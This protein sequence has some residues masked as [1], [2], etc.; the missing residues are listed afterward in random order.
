MLIR[1]GVQN[2]R[3]F[4]KESL[5][6]MLPGRT[7]QHTDH[8]LRPSQTDFELL[9]M[10]LLYGA[11]A[12]G[13]SNLVRAMAFARNL[14][15]SGTRPK[16]LLDA[17]PFRLRKDPNIVPS[18]FEFEFI[19]ENTA[20]AYGFVL[21]QRQIHEEW[22]FLIQRDKDVEEA[23]FERSTGK[24]GMTCA[25]FNSKRLEETEEQFL[26]FVARGTRPNQ[27]LL[28]ELIDKNVG[29]LDSVDRWFRHTLTIIFPESHFAGIEVGIHTDQEFAQGL[30]HFLRELHTGIDEVRL[31]EIDIESLPVPGE[32][33]DDL[34]LEFDREQESNGELPTNAL[35]VL[36]GPHKQRYMFRRTTDNKTVG[37]SLATIRR[38]GDQEIAFEISEES[39]GTQR[40]LDLFPVL[41]GLEE[42]VFVVD[43]LERSLHPNLVRRFIQHFLRGSGNNQLIVTSHEST[44]LDLSLLRR[45]EIWFVEKSSHGAST[46]YSLEEFKIRHDLDIRKGY[47]QGRFGAIPIFGSALQPE[48]LEA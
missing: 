35:V 48:P 29:A 39:D 27:L 30:A 12:S 46:L 40:L 28:T 34:T 5:L 26:Q 13:K 32:F 21:D 1:F 2:F 31:Q 20:Y 38:L 14:I 15:V 11:N 44:L 23:I 45:D 16:Q 24:D 3:S 43:E 17:Q 7:Q 18:R 25:T 10:A 6:S 19:A 47:L 4:E 33:L 36:E 41:Y 8:I 42:R 9:P 37:Y 22:L